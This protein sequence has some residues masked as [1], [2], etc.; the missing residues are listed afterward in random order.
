[1]L[2]CNENTN[3]SQAFSFIIFLHFYALGLGILFL[4]VGAVAPYILPFYLG[5]AILHENEIIW[6]RYQ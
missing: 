4:V 6:T 5:Y 2:E 1:M 3:N